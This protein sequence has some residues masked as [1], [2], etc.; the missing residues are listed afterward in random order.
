M[1]FHAE[2]PSC[3]TKRKIAERSRGKKVECEQCGKRFVA[4]ASAKSSNARKGPS[5]GLILGIGGGVL[6]LGAI[7][8]VVLVFV[9]CA[10]LGHR[11]KAFNEQAMENA[12]AAEARLKEL[13]KKLAA[14]VPIDPK[15]GSVPKGTDLSGARIV[16]PEIGD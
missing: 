1:S 2:C 12:K 16:P 4:R 9:M 6:G 11:F 15:D 5:L 3:G 14:P 10:G 7:G 13:E 8:A